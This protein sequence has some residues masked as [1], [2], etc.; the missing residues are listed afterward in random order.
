MFHTSVR[1]R[2]CNERCSFDSVGRSTRTLP[3]LT[4]TRIAEFST[5]VSSDLPLLTETVWSETVTVT[6]VGI[7]TGSLP[8][9]L[10]GS[11]NVTQDLATEASLGCFLNVLV[12]MRRRAKDYYQIY[13]EQG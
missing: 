4:V 6:P 10:M 8:I 2:P 12:A 9:L 3:S 5:R 1:V 7:L 11:P 13:L